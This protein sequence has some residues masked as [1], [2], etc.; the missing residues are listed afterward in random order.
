MMAAYVNVYE[1]IMKFGDGIGEFRTSDALLMEWI[2]K[3]DKLIGLPETIALIR[4]EYQDNFNYLDLKLGASDTDGYSELII[5]KRILKEYPAFKEGVWNNCLP[6]SDRG[7]YILMCYTVDGAVHYVRLLTRMGKV[8]DNT[9]KEV[10]LPQNA[11]FRTLE[12]TVC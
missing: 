1:G 12:D 2:K 9:G 6:Y 3:A 11:E 7:R 10:V 4:K 5:S 8:F